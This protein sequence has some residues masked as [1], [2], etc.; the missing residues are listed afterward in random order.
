VIGGRVALVLQPD[1]LATLARSRTTVLVTGTNGKTTTTA[2]V[3][4]AVAELDLVASNSSGANMPDGL[5]AAL[6]DQPSAP[7]AVLEVD[8]AH[9]PEVLARTAPAVVVLLNL[10]RD[11]MDRVGEVRRTER[12]LR[13]ALSSY[14]SV[15]VVASCD[16]VLIT[17]IAAATRHP[18]W[19]AAGAAWQADSIACPRCG[20]VVHDRTGQWWCRC[21]LA[22]PRP[23]WTLERDGVRAPDGRHVPLSL[24][25]PG[26]ANLGNAA[27]AAA[28]AVTVGV[29]LL[30]ALSRIRS[31]SDVAGRYRI[32]DH[33]GRRARLLLAKN[34]ASWRETLTQVAE[35]DRPVILAIN[36][37]EADGR[38]PSWLWDVSFDQ[39][40][41]RQV[42]VGGER[43]LDLAVRLTY[44]QLS[45]TVVSD[46]LAAV[47]QVPAGAVDVIANYTA[48]QDL[49]RRLSHGR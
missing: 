20:D 19:V 14:P 17:S 26:L 25:V 37:R 1:A 22:R 10:S 46:P 21:G 16:D 45:H 8:E 18:V 5:V 23:D 15:T 31:I 40:A 29:P 4:Q 3:A 39:L 49:T 33:H 34:P 6:A 13:E 38:D 9:L 36:A 7:Y 27:M 35:Y 43:G 24:G 32:V 44:A 47:T 30:P 28:A 2:M 11:Q 41:G 42:I 12:V 48:F